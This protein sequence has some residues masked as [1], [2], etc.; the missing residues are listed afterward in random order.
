LQVQRV[1]VGF[2]GFVEAL[3]AAHSLE[4]RGRRSL[5]PGRSFRLLLVGSFEAID[6]ARGLEWRSADSR[7]LREVLRLEHAEPGGADRTGGRQGTP[8]PGDLKGP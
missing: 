8:F 5:P 3:C 6:S 1:A 7:S 4:R 2:D